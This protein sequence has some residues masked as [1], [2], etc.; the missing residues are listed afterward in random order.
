MH[1]RMKH[2]HRKIISISITLI[3]IAVFVV[4][5]SALEVQKQRKRCER[6]IEL[7]YAIEQVIDVIREDQTDY[8]LD[9]LCET[10]EYCN[11]YDLLNED[12]LIP[13]STYRRLRTVFPDLPAEQ[14]PQ[15]K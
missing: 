7:E 3:V 4:L 13:D 1:L 11:L 9:V 2:E 12:C 14:A 15:W 10:E 6:C 8:Y 5:E